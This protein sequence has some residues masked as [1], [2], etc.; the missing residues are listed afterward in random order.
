[1]NEFIST[2]TGMKKLQ[3][4]ASK[5]I[6]LHVGKSCNETLCSNLSVGAWKVEAVTDTSSGKCYQ[7]ESFGGQ[8]VMKVKADQMYLG[9]I[10]A[11]DGSH[12]KNVQARK[13]KG[14]GIIN[15]IMQ[16]MQSMFFGKYYFEVA[17]LL[18]SSLLLS[19]LL[20]NSE[21]WVNLSDKYKLM[22]SS[23]LNLGL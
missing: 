13:N 14:V 4:G 20:L 2:K 8:E 15:K 23:C 7:A 18:R 21:A 17:L 22:K 16:I 19:S 11:A 10:I 3:F 5:G 6:K 12:K 9:D 1:M